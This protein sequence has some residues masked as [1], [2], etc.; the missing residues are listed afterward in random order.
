MIKGK[1]HKFADNVNTDEIIPA[2][3]LNL[4]D[5]VELG[6]H[7]METVDPDFPQ[8]VSAGDIMVAGNNFGCGSSREH[9]P[10][11]IKGVG[12]S[13]VIAKSFARIFFRNCI[14]IGLPILEIQNTDEINAGDELEVDLQK[15]VVKNLTQN[16]TYQSQPFPAFMQEIVKA[17]GLM[18]WTK[19][20]IKK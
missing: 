20:V 2:K 3:Y 1:A 10:V 5:P 11:A 4:T 12:I 13:C 15:G 18:Q 7:C 9:A 17:G 16:K 6:R 19:G 8:K 14:N